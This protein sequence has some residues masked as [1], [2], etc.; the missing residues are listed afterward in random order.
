MSTPAL[1]AP[2]NKASQLDWF[3]GDWLIQS[4]MRRKEGDWAEDTCESSVSKILGGHALLEKFW[5]TLDSDPID[6]MSMRVY[7]PA[8]ERWEQAWLDTSGKR[9]SVFYGQY[10]DAQ[11]IGMSRDSVENPNPERYVREVFFDIQPDGF[12]WKLEVSEDN[13]VWKIIWE[14]DYTRK[15]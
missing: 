15:S 4:R 14:L 6:A 3:L 13:T 8:N 11:F 12:Q 7:C 10:A 2:V 9:I 5:G 1:E